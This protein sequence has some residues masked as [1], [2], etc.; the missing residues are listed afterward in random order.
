MGVAVFSLVYENGIIKLIFH[1]TH[2][3]HLFRNERSTNFQ[4]TEPHSQ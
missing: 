3:K 2:K 1:E 4:G